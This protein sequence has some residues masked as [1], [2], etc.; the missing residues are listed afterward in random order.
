MKRIHA[1]HITNPKAA[2]QLSW[3]RLQ[4]CY[5]TPE[6]VEIALFK[7]L[8]NFPRLSARDNLK[9]RELSDL[10]MEQV[11]SQKRWI[12]RWPGLPRHALQDKTHSGEVACRKTL[13]RSTR[14]ST[15]QPPPFSFFMDFVYGQAKA[16]NDPNFSQSINSQPYSKGER[17]QF[18]PSGFKTPIAVHRC[19]CNSHSIHTYYTTSTDNDPARYCPVHRKA[20]PLDRCRSFR[21]KTLQERKTILKEH[22]RC[23]KCCSPNHLAKDCQATLKCGECDSERHCSA[24]HPDITA[25]P[26]ISHSTNRY[27]N[28]RQFPTQSD[29]TVHQCLR[30]G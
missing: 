9:L 18:K 4:E 24:M 6:I 16:R 27:S 30:Q 21:M 14:N 1:V 29:V 23:F 10:L 20:H 15:E 26:S 28:T 2:L 19:V 3:D 5:G 7:R 22:K 25:F 13:A 17:T 11:S 8:D 12:S